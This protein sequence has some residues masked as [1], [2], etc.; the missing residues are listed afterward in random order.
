MGTLNA[1][2]R[3]RYVTVGEAEPFVEQGFASKL[4]LKFPDFSDGRIAIEIPFEWTM[5]QSIWHVEIGSTIDT[6]TVERR[7]DPLWTENQIDALSVP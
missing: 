1:S 7:V 6:I 5:R 4:G 2:Q 3:W